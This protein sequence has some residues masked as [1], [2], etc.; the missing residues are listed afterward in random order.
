[1]MLS[2]R[3]PHLFE[4]FAERLQG[5]FF[6]HGILAG[7][8][9]RSKQRAPARGFDVKREL[10]LLVPGSAPGQ[11]SEKVSKIAQMFT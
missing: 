4:S 1:M 7:S 11:K 3:S 5:R 6:G 8:A 2:S 9:A 10:E